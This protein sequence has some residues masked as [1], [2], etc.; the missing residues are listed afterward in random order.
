MNNVKKMLKEFF[1]HY[2]I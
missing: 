2:K 1:F